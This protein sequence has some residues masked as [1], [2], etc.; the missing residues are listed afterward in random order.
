MGRMQLPKSAR[1]HQ[2]TPNSPDKRMEAQGSKGTEGD[3]EVPPALR[4][5][6]PG[7]RVRHVIS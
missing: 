6:W 1:I 5:R 4:H 3:C 2:C 7:G